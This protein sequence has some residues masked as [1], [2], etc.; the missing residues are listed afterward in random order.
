MNILITGGRGYLGGRLC[1]FIYDGDRHAVRCISRSKQALNRVSAPIMV[2]DW[3]QEDTLRACCQGIDV[4]IHLAAMNS[5]DCEAN[6][7]EALAVNVLATA[8]L[9]EA[10]KKEKVRRFVYLSTAHVY[11]SPMVGQISEATW[12]K[13]IYPYATSHRAAED[14]IIAADQRGQ[15]EGI[16]LR[17]SN[18]FGAPTDPA[19]N[20]WD[21]I[22]NNLCRQSVTTGTLILH[23]S[24]LQRRD[25]IPL[26]DVCRAIIHL[27]ELPLDSTTSRLFNVGGNW[28]PTVWEVANLIA[29]RSEVRTGQR[30]TLVRVDPC[31]EEI[32]PDFVYQTKRLYATGFRL[33]TDRIE[34]LD[35]LLEFCERN[36][37]GTERDCG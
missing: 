9:L 34:E 18:A 1:G 12:P 23:S 20:C 15:I 22:F 36:W 7:V 30:P 4:I 21:L 13:P 25:F 26:T 10:A 5:P 28:A 8:R 32:I 27:S 19:A 14:L 2:S 3:A 17:L 6:P 29:D 11:G 37:A 16:V 31:V 33:T 35:T 24:G